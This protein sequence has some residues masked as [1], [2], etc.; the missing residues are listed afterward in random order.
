[1][2]GSSLTALTLLGLATTVG[3]YKSVQGIIFGILL[4]D[5]F[6][7]LVLFGC[8]FGVSFLELELSFAFE[9]FEKVAHLTD[10]FVLQSLE[11][12]VSK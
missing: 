9:A 6:T 2:I 10:S 12:S 3:A 8:I 7:G 5:L 11:L 1:M 4:L